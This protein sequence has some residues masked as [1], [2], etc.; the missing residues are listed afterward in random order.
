MEPIQASCLLS[1]LATLSNGVVG[2]RWIAPGGARARFLLQLSP[3]LPL[4][5]SYFR[6]KTHIIG[7]DARSSLGIR[8]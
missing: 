4:V 6:R 1:Q 3:G 5:R 8:M 2:I 7:S